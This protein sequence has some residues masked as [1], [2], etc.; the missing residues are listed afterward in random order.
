MF[1]NLQEFHKNHFNAQILEYFFPS[2]DSGVVS[3]SADHFNHLNH[4]N[5]ESPNSKG[6]TDPEWSPELIQML[7]FSHEFR[8]NKL[9]NE[10]K[11]QQ[12]LE[13]ESQSSVNESKEGKELQ[14]YEN[15]TQRQR[16]M[17]LQTLLKEKEDQ[18]KGELWPV[19]SCRRF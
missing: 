13:N 19:L 15:E 18:H 11:Y 6:K 7:S 14:M 17:E 9:Q 4:F 12:E 16:I 2:N 1:S 3:E 8:K 5:T 10:K